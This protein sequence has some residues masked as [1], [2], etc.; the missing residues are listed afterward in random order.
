MESLSS[1]SSV[2]ENVRRGLR[3]F[4]LMN[5]IGTL[6]CARGRS[7]CWASPPTSP[8]RLAR[9]RPSR[10]RAS[11]AIASSLGFT[12]HTPE[13][14]FHFQIARTVGWAKAPLRRAHHQLVVVNGGHA[15]LCPPYEFV[16][17]VLSS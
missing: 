7:T 8:I 17:C 9:P 14:E 11:S 12:Q 13:L 4:G 16:Q 2:S 1:R 6:R 15:S 3:G 10:E 5:S